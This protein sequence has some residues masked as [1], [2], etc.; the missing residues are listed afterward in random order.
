METCEHTRPAG[1]K[2]HHLRCLDLIRDSGSVNMWGGAEPLRD[3]FPELTE[4]QSAEILIYWMRTFNPET[5]KD[6][7]ANHTSI[8]TY[9]AWREADGT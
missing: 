3:V 1:C 8:P 4:E 7:W 9:R 2:D 6:R 5:V